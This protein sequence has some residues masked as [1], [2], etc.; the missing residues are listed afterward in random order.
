[1]QNKGAR[2]VRALFLNQ[3]KEKIIFIIIFGKNKERL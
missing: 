1:M 3:K 2:F